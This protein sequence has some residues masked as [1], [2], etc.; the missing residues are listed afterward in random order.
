LQNA[1]TTQVM[2][3]QESVDDR[4]PRFVYG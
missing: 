3:G 2:A 1:A 4:V